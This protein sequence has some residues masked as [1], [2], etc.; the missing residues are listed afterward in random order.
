MPETYAIRV[1]K[2]MTV[3]S[4]CRHK[5]AVILTVCWCEEM[6]VSTLSVEVL[7]VSVGRKIGNPHRTHKPCD[8]NVQGKMS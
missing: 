6:A 1:I 4:N 8:Y 2:Y 5:N 3:Y 7:C